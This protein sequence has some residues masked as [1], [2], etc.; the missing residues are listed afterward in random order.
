M[1]A[2]PPAVDIAIYRDEH[3]AAVSA[4]WQVVFP[5]DPP[6]NR[7]EIAIPEKLRLQPDLFFVALSQRRVVGTAMAGYYGQRGCFRFLQGAWLC[8]RGTGH[9]GQE[10]VRLTPRQQALCT[11][12]RA[13]PA[14]GR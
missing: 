1:T 9:H 3:F 5:G 14:I 12:K 4:L 7:A 8:G 6:W 2:A 13:E 11:L 10:N